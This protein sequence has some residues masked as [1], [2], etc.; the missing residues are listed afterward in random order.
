MKFMKTI[1]VLITTDT[2]TKQIILLLN[3]AQPKENKFILHDLDEE[4]LFIDKEYIVWLKKEVE[5]RMD[6]FVRW[7]ATI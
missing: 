2:C 6:S 3:E 4:H 5:S 1:G 7:E